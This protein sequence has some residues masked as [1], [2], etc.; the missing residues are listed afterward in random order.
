MCFGYCHQITLLQAELPTDFSGQRDLT[1]LLDTDESSFYHTCHYSESHTLRIITANRHRSKCAWRPGKNRWGPGHGWQ[2]H[3]RRF[4]RVDGPRG[5][6]APVHRMFGTGMTRRGVAGEAERALKSRPGRAARRRTAERASARDPGRERTVEIPFENRFTQA[7]GLPTERIQTKVRPRLT[8]PLKAFIA[9]SPMLV[10]ATSDREGRCDASPKGGPRA[11]SAC[12]MIGP[13]GAGRRGQQ[14]LSVLS[15][16][17]AGPTRRILF[18]IRA[19]GMGRRGGRGVSPSWSGPSW[20]GGAS[21]GR[22][23]PRRE[24]RRGAG[25]ERRGSKE[26]YTGWPASAELPRAAVNERG[27]RGQA[28]GA[29]ARARRSPAWRMPALPRGRR[30][31]RRCSVPVTDGASGSV[32]R[33]RA[34]PR[35][36]REPSSAARRPS[37]DWSPL[38]CSSRR[39]LPGQGAGQI[40]GAGRV[41]GDRLRPTAAVRQR[42]RQQLATGTAGPARGKRARQQVPF[43]SRRL[44]HVR[45]RQDP[46]A[47]GR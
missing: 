37:G 1:L 30:M 16:H 22:L 34:H 42:E 40:Q 10:M 45:P 21:T 20:T 3:G 31:A 38:G 17:G 19:V 24:R 23:R 44:V 14:A 4:A 29:P 36:R 28:T 12:W 39:G 7:F 18:F 32:R 25:I 9:E 6:T 43:R 47:P 15:E 33:W 26:A 13:A 27:R 2:H 41:Q 35:Q 46:D 8:E 5:V 11:S